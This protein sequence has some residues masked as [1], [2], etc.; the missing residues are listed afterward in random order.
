MSS[1]AFE[2]AIP[3]TKEMQDY[4]LVLDYTATVISQ[5]KY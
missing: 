2:P 1:A 3:A 5:Q 4:A